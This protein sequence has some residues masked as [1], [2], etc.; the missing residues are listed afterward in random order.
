M[1]K[2]MFALDISIH[3]CMTLYVSIISH[4]V[5]IFLELSNCWNCRVAA[6]FIDTHNL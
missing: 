1:K 3:M 5:G 4:F 2:K 6:N